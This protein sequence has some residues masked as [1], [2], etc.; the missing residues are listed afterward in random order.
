M[1]YPSIKL[2]QE[3]TAKHYGCTVLAMLS[4]RMTRN[5][6]RPRQVAMYLAREMTLHSLPEIGRLFNRDHTTVGHACKAVERRLV[7]NAGEIGEVFLLRLEID[8][9]IAS[10]KEVDSPP[11]RSAKKPSSGGASITLAANWDG[12]V[13]QAEEW[14]VPSKGRRV[15]QIKG[16]EI[17]P[18]DVYHPYRFSVRPHARGDMPVGAVCHPWEWSQRGL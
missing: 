10:W 4:T 7:E 17:L 11:P 15:Y 6:T 16:V 13:P 3:C 8:E 5:L 2:I 9:G 14:L 18:E 1:Q 12:P